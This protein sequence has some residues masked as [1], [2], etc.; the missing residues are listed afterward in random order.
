MDFS[1]EDLHTAVQKHITRGDGNQP[2][3]ICIILYN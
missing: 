3:V 1:S 2:R